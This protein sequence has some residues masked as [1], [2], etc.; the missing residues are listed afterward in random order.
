MKC[1]KMTYK[2][3]TRKY[4]RSVQFVSPEKLYCVLYLGLLIIKDEIQVGDLLRFV[5]EG[6]LSFN[7]Y[8]HLLQ[9]DMSDRILGIQTNPKNTM[10]THKAVRTTTFRLAKLLGVLDYIV[11]PNIV[12]LC[13][14]YCREMNLPDEIQK[15]VKTL[16]S[17]TNPAFPIRKHKECIPNYEARCMSI[18]LFVM[19]LYFGM[20]GVTE[21]E[22]SKYA[23]LLNQKGCESN[24]FNLQEWLLHMKFRRFVIEQNHFPTYHETDRSRIDS[25][26]YLQYIKSHDIH[27]GE[28]SKLTKEMTKYKELLLRL[29]ELQHD[30]ITHL[31]FPPSL[32]PFRDYTRKIV[33][34]FRDKYHSIL[35]SDFS[36]DNI[37]FLKSH[38]IFL[39]QIGEEVR[40]KDGGANSNVILEKVKYR[41]MSN[42]L[43]C[44]VVELVD[45]SQ[46]EDKNI[47]KKREFLKK[48]KKRSRFEN[49]SINEDV[50]Y[51]IHYLPHKKYWLYNTVGLHDLAP[52][53]FNPFLKK[54]P[55]T[56]MQVFEE[57]CRIIEQTPADLF[58]TFQHT[59]LCLVYLV[60]YSGDNRE[61]LVDK[62]LLFQIREAW[63][64]W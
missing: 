64:C 21:Y 31:P 47:F 50:G 23:R 52:E 43:A 59:E 25:D 60:D 37:A 51:K 20:D 54:Y 15:A 36:N 62:K 48:K 57:C 49:E 26:L 61:V 55:H 53:Y 8:T 34:V 7:N 63:N 10:L 45:D 12:K 40:I 1:H 24:F 6:H 18:I 9:D 22:L 19:K 13:E 28:R 33:E 35:K 5:R 32:T 14:R 46:K 16:I 2:D 42:R 27:F 4:L 56:F 30:F 44:S 38:D 41:T 3:R 39:P 29:K 58:Q 11:V 17:I